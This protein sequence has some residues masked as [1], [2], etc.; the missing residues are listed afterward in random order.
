MGQGAARRNGPG[1][2][3]FRVLLRRGT[4]LMAI[5]IRAGLDNQKVPSVNLSAPFVRGYSRAPSPGFVLIG[6]VIPAHANQFDLEAPGRPL[7]AGSRE[8]FL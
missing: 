3:Q 8:G 7:Q 4:V 5:K 6:P 1:V 2:W